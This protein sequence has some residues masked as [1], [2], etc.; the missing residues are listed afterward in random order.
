[1]KID[2]WRLW[3]CVYVF[4]FYFDSCNPNIELYIYLLLPLFIF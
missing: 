2:D 1:M 3:L 4:C